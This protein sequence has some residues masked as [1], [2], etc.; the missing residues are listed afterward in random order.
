[1]TETIKPLYKK[2]LTTCF[3]LNRPISQP[4]MAALKLEHAAAA[5]AGRNLAKVFNE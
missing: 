4:M 5:A 2:K 3:L 1:M